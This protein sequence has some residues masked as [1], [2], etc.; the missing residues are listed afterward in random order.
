[1]WST[2]WFRHSLGALL[3]IASCLASSACAAPAKPSGNTKAHAGTVAAR[4][5]A[6]G[7]EIAIFAGG[8]FWCM[9][10]QFEGMRGIR[11]VVSGYTGGH[12]P[13]PTY[14][15]VGAGGTGHYE[16]V[17]IRY[18]PRVITYEKLLDIFWHSVDPTQGDGQFCDR[19]DQ[20]RSAI[21]Y[22]DETQHRLAEQ[23]KQRILAS[24]V[25]EKPIVTSIV[26]ASTFYP[27]EG[28][29][30]D[31]WKKDPIRYQSYRL[32]CGRDKRLRDVWGERAAK[33]NVH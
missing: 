30:Q 29:H 5:A 21:F 28:Y 19:G 23:S 8:C 15:E 32:G 27:A 22:R 26:A 12:Q 4:P 10:T 33:P 11:S 17:E 25:L 31:F 7:E 13:N 18:D 3:A 24:G 16:S 1:M 9:E 6:A 14:E 2:R 20:Y